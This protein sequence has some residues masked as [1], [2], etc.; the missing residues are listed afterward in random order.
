MN[1]AKHPINDFS[2]YF[3]DAKHQYYIDTEKN[4]EYW[5]KIPSVTQFVNHYTPPFDV[6]KI[7]ALSARKHGKTADEVKAEWERK[8]NAACEMGTRVHANQEKHLKGLT[9]YEQPKDARERQIMAFGWKA[10]EDMLSAGFKPLD[11]EKM[12]F[13]LTMK[14]AGTI[15][16]LFMKGRVLYIVDWKTNEQIKT[17]NEYHQFMLPP[18]ETLEDSALN[19]YS[20]Q[21]NLYERILKRDR[22]IPQIQE[23]KKMLVHLQPT[24]Y[25]II[26]IADNPI[27]DKLLLDYLAFDWYQ[28]TPF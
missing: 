18:A 23:V 7:A 3:D 15:D 4:V 1:S 27:A 12:V 20:L 11:A 24:N 10:I 25:Q 8:K 21:L 26:P 17:C 19:H 13:S 5:Q 2:V 22:Y 6:D 14:L 16:A 28:E 9:D